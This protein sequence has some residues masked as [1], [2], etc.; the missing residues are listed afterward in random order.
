MPVDKIRRSIIFVEKTTRG[1]MYCAA[2]EHSTSVAFDEK[3]TCL[4]MKLV[5]YSTAWFLSASVE[6]MKT[7]GDVF[8]VF[9]V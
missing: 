3:V 6:D 9:F 1:I 7:S 2:T 4:S 5:S 8:N